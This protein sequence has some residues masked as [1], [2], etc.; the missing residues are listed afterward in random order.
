MPTQFNIDGKLVKSVIVLIA[1][2]FLLY[3][4]FALVTLVLLAATGVYLAAYLKKLNLPHPL[5]ARSLKYVAAASL[6][7]LPFAW[8][9]YSQERQAFAEKV[10][11]D[12]TMA[13]AK[14]HILSGKFQ[15]V[16]KALTKLEM[17]GV[18]EAKPLFEEIQPFLSEEKAKERVLGLSRGDF[19]KISSGQV[20]TLSKEQIVNDQLNAKYRSL[21]AGLKAEFYAKKE[22]DEKA[23]KERA[24]VAAAA[25]REAERDAAIIAKRVLK[26]GKAPE[27]SGWDGSYSEVKRF[28]KEAANDPGSIDIT[29]CT[30]VS[31]DEKAG[32]VVGCD[33]R[34]KN[35]FGALMKF[36]NWF[37]IRHGQVVKML[38]ANSYR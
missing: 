31:I 20:L 10:Y 17:R 37:V 29:G 34:G 6:V 4:P 9:K 36:S 27:Q 13:E 35:G 38:P 7:A 23:A 2:W 21:A 14:L 8:G 18:S 28:L 5:I 25:A 1:A 33:Y 19:E 26:F 3:L 11:I 16:A 22:K 32:Y 30:K 12:A 24:R 15:D